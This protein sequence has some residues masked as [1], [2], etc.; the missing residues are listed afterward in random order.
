[1]RKISFLLFFSLIF[2]AFSSGAPLRI[3]SLS[4]DIT[5]SLYL[6]GLEDRVIGV[7]RYCPRKEGK[8]IVGSVLEINVEKVFSLHP[9]LV[10]GT[11]EGNPKKPIEKL[12]SLG[13]NVLIL[14]KESRVKDIFDNFILLGKAVGKER[15]ARRIVQQT[16]ATLEAIKKRWAGKS[17]RRVFIQVGTSPLVAAGGNT[18]ITD[19]VSYAGGQNIFSDLARYPRI[20]PEE[21][22]RRDPQVILILTMSEQG[23]FLRSWERLGWQKSA[24]FLLNADSYGSLTPEGV[25]EGVEKLYRILW[26]G[27]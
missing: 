12:K 15:Q 2:S 3:V 5:K 21:V 4:P 9:D 10:I 6:L 16:R 19:M 25:G 23:D 26:G 17:P 13:L 22:V 8:E 1:M 24:L 20:N 18:P 7:T 11:E 14:G 27:Q